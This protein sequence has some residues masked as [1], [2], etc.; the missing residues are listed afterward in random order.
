[1]NLEVKCCWEC[2]FYIHNFGESYYKCSNVNGTP[3]LGHIPTSE[4]DVIHKNCP[5]RTEPITVTLQKPE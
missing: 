3:Y 5:L 1:M 4:G 2:P